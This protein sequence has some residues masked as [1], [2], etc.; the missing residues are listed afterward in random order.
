MNS[1]AIQKNDARRF[2]VTITSPHGLSWR[3]LDSDGICIIE[4]NCIKDANGNN[5]TW[6]IEVEKPGIYEFRVLH[7]SIDGVF[8]K[9][10]IPVIA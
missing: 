6:T 4:N 5:Y 10:I 2:T 3:P 1:Y 7:Q 8:K 9:L